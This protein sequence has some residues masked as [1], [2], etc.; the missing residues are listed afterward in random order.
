[1]KSD[2]T[3][4]FD[5]GAILIIAERFSIQVIELKIWFICYV[6]NVALVT[7]QIILY[8]SMS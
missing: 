8:I 4:G 2:Q 3:E 1:M 7:S 5:I 6:L